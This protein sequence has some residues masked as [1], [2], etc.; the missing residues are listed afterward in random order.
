MNSEPLPRLPLNL[1]SPSAY[2]SFYDLPT[3]LLLGQT[4]NDKTDEELRQMLKVLQEERTSPMIRQAKV[5][6]ESD[7]IEGKK[8]K[9]VRINTDDLL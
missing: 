6:R 4:I 1:T 9:V 7:K 5:R 3:E 2:Q 8:S